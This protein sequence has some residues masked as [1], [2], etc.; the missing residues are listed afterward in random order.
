[1]S[2]E[3]ETW[4]KTPTREY[5][6]Q[7]PK[8]YGLLKIHKEGVPLRPIMSSI[9]FVTYKVAKELSRIL[10]PLVDKSIY[11]V[12]NSKEFAEKSETLD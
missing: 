6:P 4:M 8:C 1:M 3:K 9:G 2:N 12:N 10:K 11:H 7:G 5:I